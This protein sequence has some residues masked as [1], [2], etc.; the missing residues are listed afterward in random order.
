MSATPLAILIGALGGQ[1]GGVLVD[2]LVEAAYSAG[3]PVQATSIPGVAQRTGATTYYVEMLPQPDAPAGPVFCPYPSAGMVDVF[4]ALEPTEAGRAL[5]AGYITG[6][7][8][9]ICSAARI[10]S[11]AEKVIAGNGALS[12]PAML[13]ATA[14]AAGRLI[15]VDPAEQPGA[16]LN[17]RILG[18][19]LACEALPIEPAA[20]QAAIEAK[21]LAVSANLNA[22]ALGLQTAGQRPTL[23]G[24]ATR[25][26][27]PPPS[28]AG[29]LDDFPPVLRPLLG[30]ALA[31][32]VDYQDE[33]YA[34]RYLERL[35][36]ALAADRQAGGAGR[37][38]RLTAE[39][40]RP[41]AAWMSYEDLP[42]VAQL[43]TRP[44]RLA[45]IRAELGAA[46][47]EPVRVADYL[48]PS[49]E[50]A[51]D[52]LPGRL[53]RRLSEGPSPAAFPVVWPTSSPWGFLALRMLA[54]FRRWR[55]RSLNFAQEQRAI[56]GWL[57][58]T[59]AAA[60]VNYELA[61][62]MARLSVWARGYG[63]IRERGLCRLQET[64]AGWPGRLRDEPDALLRDVE[65]SLL[66]AAN[67]PD[68]PCN[69]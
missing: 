66:A 25:Y 55:P 27:S 42:R 47:G 41:L 1:G 61:C 29:A 45:R 67:D 11:T 53:A 36:P 31:R 22:F 65:A 59:V 14:D 4:L 18:A 35:Q 7:T 34:R 15:L 58:A 52:L 44:G 16:P 51:A 43:K 46:P 40:A 50:Q 69:Q 37:D 63:R 19:L 24:P 5:A 68:S 17:A 9:V 10:Y 39:V 48:T 28:L 23:H 30:H 21:G 12:L 33:A 57:E 62:R 38:Y 6:R 2:W 26:D 3:Y 60:A 64:L 32:L 49:L 13:Q 54:G 56:E 20:V 8:T